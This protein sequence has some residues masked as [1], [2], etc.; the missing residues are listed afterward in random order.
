M[1]LWYSA[2]DSLCSPLNGEED[3]TELVFFCATEAVLAGGTAVLETATAAA[4]KH[5]ALILK[6][7]ALWEHEDEIGASFPMFTKIEVEGKNVRFTVGERTKFIVH[8]DRDE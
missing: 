7:G 2:D 8:S 4:A 1:K 5:S 3:P 6:S